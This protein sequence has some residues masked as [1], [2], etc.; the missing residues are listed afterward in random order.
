MTI[1]TLIIM[2]TTTDGFVSTR[3]HLYDSQEKVDAK[4]EKEME[5]LIATGW[6]RANQYLA[7]ANFGCYKGAK[8]EFRISTNVVQ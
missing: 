8:V 3:P 1:Y 7:K 6:D 5:Y 2:Q 4:I